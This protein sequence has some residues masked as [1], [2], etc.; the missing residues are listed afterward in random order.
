[1]TLTK[2]DLKQFRGLLSD[3]RSDLRS[4]IHLDMKVLLEQELRPLKERVEQLYRM[5]NDDI[6]LAFK[7]IETLKKRI[8]KLETR[9]SSLK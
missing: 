4:E 2:D 6:G 3:F 8:K 5:V 9:V 1:M 7:E